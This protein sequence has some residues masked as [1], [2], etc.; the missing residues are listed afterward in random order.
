MFTQDGKH[1]V[2]EVGGYFTLHDVRYVLSMHQCRMYL[3]CPIYLT[4]NNGTIVDVVSA[5]EYPIRTFSSGATNSMR[6]HISSSVFKA[7]QQTIHIMVAGVAFIA[8]FSVC[9]KH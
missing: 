2:Q 5:M 9:N 6:Q 1:W 3:S 8:K 4:Q 7:S